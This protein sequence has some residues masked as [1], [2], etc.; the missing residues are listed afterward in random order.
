MQKRGQ[1]VRSFDLKGLHQSQNCFL[2]NEDPR[3]RNVSPFLLVRYTYAPYQLKF[4]SAQCSA[5]VTMDGDT[6]QSVA[7]GS[8]ACAVLTLVGKQGVPV[9]LE[10]LQ[11][12]GHVVQCVREDHFFR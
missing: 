8:S 4:I 11:L 7:C 2:T 6:I 3:G 1:L 9:S 10:L 5:R 12:Q